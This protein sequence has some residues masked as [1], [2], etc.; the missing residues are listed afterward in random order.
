[1]LTLVGI[2]AFVTFP[3]DWR[4]FSSDPCSSIYRPVK[5]ILVVVGIVLGLVDTN[6]FW[7]YEYGAAHD[8]F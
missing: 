2:A 6:A 1:M 4:F 7:S 3:C 8:E 5:V